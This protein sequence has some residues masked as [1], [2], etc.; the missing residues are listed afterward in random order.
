MGEPPAAVAKPAASCP[1]DPSPMTFPTATIRIPQKAGD[2]RP[3]HVELATTPD[4]TARGLMY[5][6]SMAPDGGMLFDLRI[7]R[8]QAFWMRNTCI[9]LDMFFIDEDGLIVG[10]LEQ[11][12][13]LND[14]ERTVGCPSRYVLETN[15]GFARK[16]GI[17]PGQRVQ[18]P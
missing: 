10:I 13:T 11:V 9:P 4:Q 17:K 6:R 1:K 7:R 8:P 3:M 15:A 12:P 14:E 16:Q 2:A 5:R 18:L